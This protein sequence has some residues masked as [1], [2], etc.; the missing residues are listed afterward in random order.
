M[1]TL[2]KKRQ[3]NKEEIRDFTK[4]WPAQGYCPL[5]SKKNKLCKCEKL[6]CHCNILAIECKWPECLCDIC[7]ELKCKCEINE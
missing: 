6:N 7:L 5:C 3:N 4:P 2:C 1:I